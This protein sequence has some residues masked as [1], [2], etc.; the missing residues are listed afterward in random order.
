MGWPAVGSSCLGTMLSDPYLSSVFVSNLG[1]RSFILIAWKVTLPKISSWVK[2]LPLVKGAFP[3]FVWFRWKFCNHLVMKKS[4]TPFTVYNVQVYN[5]VN[6]RRAVVRRVM[7]MVVLW[8]CI[9]TLHPEHV[10]KVTGLHWKRRVSSGSV[11]CTKPSILGPR[12]LRRQ[13]LCTLSPCDNTW[14]WGNARI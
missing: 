11:T 14:H 2:V 5:A 1:M 3:H 13:T 6:D 8:Q 7:L 4:H 9:Q 10:K 12:I